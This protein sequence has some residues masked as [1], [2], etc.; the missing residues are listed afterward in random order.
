M[1]RN[2]E[3]AAIEPTDRR[4]Q[5]DEVNDEDENA[6]RRDDTDRTCVRQ[7]STLRR[8]RIGRPASLI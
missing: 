1:R 4:I 8:R 6:G 2:N 7:R 5:P 3:L